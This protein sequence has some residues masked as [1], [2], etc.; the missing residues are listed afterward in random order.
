[1]YDIVVSIVV[2]FIECIPFL[3]G[4]RI[5]FDSMRMFLFRD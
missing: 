5:L 4:V 3:I 2:E 1:M